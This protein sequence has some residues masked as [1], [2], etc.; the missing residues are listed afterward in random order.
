MSIV[1]GLLFG[2]VIGLCLKAFGCHAATLTFQWRANT[3]PDLAG[4][5]L[6]VGPSA[7]V[8]TQAVVILSPATN[9]TLTDVTGTN[10]FA[11]SAFNVAGLESMPTAPISYVAP[12]PP[13]TP[14]GFEGSWLMLITDSSCDA[15]MWQ[16]AITN[17]VPN[18]WPVEFFRLRTERKPLQ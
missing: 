15:V 18:I 14:T 13:I 17:E 16:A 2:I 6:Y 11:L 5:K 7:M 10:Y 9:Y 4:Y 3:E 8:Y 12:S 1:K